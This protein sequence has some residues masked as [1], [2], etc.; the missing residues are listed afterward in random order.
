MEMSLNVMLLRRGRALVE[1]LSVAAA[2]YITSES[3]NA[4]CLSFMIV[5]SSNAH[6]RRR[7]SKHKRFRVGLRRARGDKVQEH[8]SSVHAKYITSESISHRERGPESE[9][10]ACRPLFLVK[11]T[12]K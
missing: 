4:F 9:T 1:N 3:Y 8:Q 11:R 2:V 12:A 7:Q 5:S 6:R 10:N